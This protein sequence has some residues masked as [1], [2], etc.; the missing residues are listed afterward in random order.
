MFIVTR[1]KIFNLSW[2]NV[3]RLLKR[4][5]KHALKNKIKKF[6]YSLYFKDDP[7]T[8]SIGYLIVFLII[9]YYIAFTKSIL[10][11]SLNL[12]RL[13]RISANSS[14]VCLISYSFNSNKPG[15]YSPFKKISVSSPTSPIIAITKFLGV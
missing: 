10:H 6:Q 12:I 13:C 3:L 1:W 15:R 11:L 4:W 5:I 8:F 9:F 2:S 7:L 14:P